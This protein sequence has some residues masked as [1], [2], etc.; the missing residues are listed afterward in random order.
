MLFVLTSLSTAVRTRCGVGCAVK[1]TTTTTT[2]TNAADEPG[3]ETKR[4]CYTMPATGLRTVRGTARR[5]RV[6]GCQV[7][8][9]L[10]SY[11]LVR[12][13]VPCGSLFSLPANV[14]EL[15]QC[16]AT[17]CRIEIFQTRLKIK[18][19][20]GFQEK[21]KARHRMQCQ[22]E[23]AHFLSLAL[24]APCLT[25]LTTAEKTIRATRLRRGPASNCR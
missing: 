15:T 12:P 9:I 13:S 19:I 18:S 7:E 14:R 10:H 22:V 4:E 21:G 2:P 25:N 3:W 24:V 17:S 20:S 16:S 5:R 8:A 1:G 23:R 11:T 6:S